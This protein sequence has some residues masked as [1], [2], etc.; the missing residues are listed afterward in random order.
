MGQQ[1]RTTDHFSS[2]V[3]HDLLIEIKVKVEN[4]TSEFK[5]MQSDLSVRVAKLEES[6]VTTSELAETLKPLITSDLDKET[7][8]RF[9]ERYVWGAIGIIGLINLIGF[10]TLIALLR[11]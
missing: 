2:L 4:L 11:N 6:R 5:Q 8:L 9:L 1:R 3:D 10:G 7:R